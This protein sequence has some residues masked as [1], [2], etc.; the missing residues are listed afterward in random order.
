LLSENV[1]FG[2]ILKYFKRKIWTT[3]DLNFHKS[4]LEFQQT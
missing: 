4:E 1:S 3:D 2:G